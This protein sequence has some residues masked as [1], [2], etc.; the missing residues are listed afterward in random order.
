MNAQRL[1]VGD[2]AHFTSSHWSVSEMSGQVV[3]IV[4][5]HDD[6][7]RFPYTVASLGGKRWMAVESE[8]TLVDAAT[9]EAAA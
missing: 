1:A 9:G 5:L 2:R 8:L 7:Y 6:A 4:E 3:E